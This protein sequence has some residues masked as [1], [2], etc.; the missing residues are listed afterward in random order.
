MVQKNKVHNRII[1]RDL[2]P[3]RL[4]RNNKR[5]A[6]F[7]GVPLISFRFEYLAVFS[8]K[9]IAATLYCYV[10]NYLIIFLMYDFLLKYLLCN[11]TN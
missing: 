4:N 1:S 2:P 5:K 11:N 3:S 9:K 7:T 10:K 8:R 6:P